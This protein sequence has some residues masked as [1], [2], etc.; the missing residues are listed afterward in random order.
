MTDP[1]AIRW[2]DREHRI[3]IIPAR[4]DESWVLRLGNQENVL[5]ASDLRSMLFAMRRL[6][7]Y[8]AGQ[9]SLRKAKP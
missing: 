1:H 7:D 3:G 9:R 5:S 2:F 4:E 8:R 6:R